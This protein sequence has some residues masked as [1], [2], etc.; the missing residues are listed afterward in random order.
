MLVFLEEEPDKSFADKSG[1]GLLLFVRNLGP[2]FSW[3]AY[4]CWRRCSFVWMASWLMYGAGPRIAEEL[5]NPWLHPC[6]GSGAWPLLCG[7]TLCRLHLTLQLKPVGDRWICPNPQWQYLHHL[8]LK[9]LRYWS[10][11]EVEA[12]E[13]TRNLPSHPLRV[14]GVA[15]SDHLIFGAHG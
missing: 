5:S 2:C 3:D 11:E 12:T 6:K 15:L 1:W 4:L 9:L 14:M 7:N 8:L 13:G 10:E